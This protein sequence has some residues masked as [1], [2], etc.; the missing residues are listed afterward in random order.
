MLV[1]QYAAARNFAAAPAAIPGELLPGGVH[2]AEKSLTLGTGA[3]ERAG[4]G[5]GKAAAAMLELPGEIGCLA[6][7]GRAAGKNAGEHRAG[8]ETKFTLA[9]RHAGDE[10]AGVGSFLHAPEERGTAGDVLTL[11]GEKALGGERSF[12]APAAALHNA[13]IGIFGERAGEGGRFRREGEIERLL[14]QLLCAAGEQKKREQ[15]RKKKKLF[16]HVS[17]PSARQQLARERARQH[18]VRD[19]EFLVAVAGACRVAHF[20]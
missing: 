8:G 9:V 19:D 13:G 3:F 14:R 20:V 12:K 16:F 6:A 15:R 10:R 17:L 2:A 11:A 18:I 4:V 5:P 7:H 1:R